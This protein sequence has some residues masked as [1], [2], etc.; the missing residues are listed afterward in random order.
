MINSLRGQCAE[1]G[2]AAPQSRAGIAHLITLVQDPKD[3]RLPDLARTSPVVL[4]ETLRDRI[5]GLDR[6]LLQW[7]RASLVS[8]SLGAT[9][10]RGPLTAT[11][12]TASLGDD[13]QFWNDR[14]FAASLGLVPRQ[15][16]PGRK[17]R[18]GGR[19]LQAERQ[20]SPLQ[21]GARRPLGIGLAPRRPAHHRPDRPPGHAKVCSFQ[22]PGMCSFQLSLT[23]E[24]RRRGDGQQ[25]RADR[26]G[27]GAPHQPSLRSGPALPVSS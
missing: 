4:V 14:Q 11:A 16:G 6:E 26:R 20:V 22:L 3:D 2:V 27:H 9:P 23:D 19:D 15:H 24:P 8:R 13:R 18:L 1:F 25:E 21:S 10:G 12:L 17:V 5:A 7:H